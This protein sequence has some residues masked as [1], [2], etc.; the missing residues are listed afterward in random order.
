MI[1]LGINGVSDI[2][3]D[4]SA[5]IVIDGSVIASV[6]E[7]RFN[8]VKHT[9]GI[10][11]NA[12]DFCLKK[13]GVKFS[14][15]DYVGYYLLPEL[16][17]KTFYCDVVENYGGDEPSLTCYLTAGE[18]IKNIERDL[19]NHYKWGRRT[20]FENVPHHLAHAA[21]AFYT[22][23]FDESLVLTIDGSGE[24]ESSA[25]FYGNWPHLEKKHDFLVYPFSLGFIYAHFAE[26]LG[27]PGI[28]GS[29]KLMGLAGFGKPINGLLD[30]VITLTNDLYRPIDIDLSFFNYHIT[31]AS[32]SAKGLS[33]FGEARRKSEGFSQWHY[34]LAAT[35]Q[36]ALEKSIVHL[37]KATHELYPDVERLCTSGGVSLNISANRKILELGAFKEVYFT[38]ASNDAGTSLGCAQALYHEH[39]EPKRRHLFSVYTGPDMTCDFDI[40]AA[41]DKY[42]D[43]IEWEVL[44]ADVA[45]HAAKTLAIGGIIGWAQGRMEWG[46]RALGARS[47][48]ANPLVPDIKARMDRNVKKREPFRPYAASVLQEEAHKWFKMPISNYMLLETDVLD[49][50]KHK[51]PGVVHVDGTCRPQSVSKESNPKYYDLLLNFFQITGCP[52]VLNTS[53]NMHGEPIVNTPEEILHDLLISGLDAVYINDVCV[54]RRHPDCPAS[55]LQQEYTDKN[56][57][58]ISEDVTT[59]NSSGQAT[60]APSPRKKYSPAWFSVANI[61][62]WQKAVQLWKAHGRELL[63]EQPKRPC[64]A[65]ACGD[66]TPLFQSY[67]GHAYHVCANC[68]C[69][70]VPYQ[71]DEHLFARFFVRNEEAARLARTMARNRLAVAND[72]DRDRFEMLLN[73]L[74]PSEEST[75]LDIGAN[76]GQFVSFARE[77]GFSAFGLEADPY[78]LEEARRLERPV[79][80][81]AAQLP[82]Q[83]YDMI[84][85]WETLEHV[86]D[87]HALLLFAKSKLA[88]GGIVAL[89]MPNLNNLQLQQMRESN[90]HAHGGYNTPGHINFFGINQLRVLLERVGLSV[91]YY[92]SMYSSDYVLQYGYLT[93]L[94]RGVQIGPVQ[95]SE[96][97]FEY[98]ASID[99][100][101]PY[102]YSLE[103]R[104]KTGPILFCVAGRVEDQQRH[105]SIGEKLRKHHTFELRR[106]G[107][108]KIEHKIA[109]PF[110]VAS[111]RK[112]QVVLCANNH[113]PDSLSGLLVELGLQG[114]GLDLDLLSNLRPSPVVS[115]HYTAGRKGIFFAEENVRYEYTLISKKIPLKAG[116]Y[117]LSACGGSMKGNCAMGILDVNDDV[118]L[119]PP[120]PMSNTVSAADVADWMMR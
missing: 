4:A 33:R 65:C 66:S 88:D 68:G 95:D 72:T 67:D 37:V 2:F 31:G 71:V 11:F 64:P 76:A 91:I 27:F 102:L 48:L 51:I 8:R 13:A 89:T 78:A 26:H 83:S 69:W 49:D 24:F 34:D 100:I 62:S 10:P 58:S 61:D 70:F 119:I 73:R 116:E 118:W 105:I 110:S 30:D 12:I 92:E 101:A 117:I 45:N 82:A 60:V 93:G 43:E 23:G 98:P 50:V 77:K 108:A 32:F 29:G 15:I 17:I 36:E 35:I 84:C 74:E 25:V 90:P 39:G 56:D 16:F 5:T 18:R 1:V 55:V 46:P 3:H 97:Y 47:I 22:S 99:D 87:P 20:K 79:V 81:D 7:E 106:L 86:A 38:P 114:M 112:I 96:R 41:L 9:N 59:Q 115:R 21:S 113:A 28:S 57:L 120:S 44:G 104:H 111:N 63:S 85:L 80:C 6:E 53:F 109:I 75:I 40:D 103:H 52:L 14:E 107:F 54:V 19:R 94:C 42:K